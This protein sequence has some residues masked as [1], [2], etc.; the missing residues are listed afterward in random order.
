MRRRTLN[1]DVLYKSVN[2]IAVATILD[3]IVVLLLYIIDFLPTE[4]LMIVGAL[5]GFL[6][7]VRFVLM[8]S[9]LSNLKELGYNFKLAYA[10]IFISIALQ[11]SSTIISQIGSYLGNNLLVN[12][13]RYSEI[14]IQVS[15]VVLHTAIVDGLSTILI[16]CREINLAI[17]AK[18]VRVLFSILSL[19]PSLVK[20]AYEILKDAELIGKGYIIP[21]FLVI[22]VSYLI[23]YF[24]YLA[25][26]FKTSEYFE[27]QC[28]D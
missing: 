25:F 15:D 14:V 10:W 17:Q 13:A 5:A 22:G 8:L 18:K 7:V 19:E 27:N 26:L 1:F 6:S 20:T 21:I 23:A 16:K 3:F 24:A 2:K 28:L 9:S 4:S 12:V 11:I